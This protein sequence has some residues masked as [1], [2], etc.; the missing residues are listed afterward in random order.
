MEHRH[1]FQVL[2]VATRAPAW[3]ETALKPAHEIPAASPPAER[4]LVAVKRAES[5]RP[6]L[7]SAE[8]KQEL[9]AAHIK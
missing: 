3:Q 8:G 1:S 7:Y 9:E 2:L 6:P 5:P 4:Q